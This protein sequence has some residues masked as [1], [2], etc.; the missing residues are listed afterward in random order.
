MYIHTC[1]E[2]VDAIKKK[3]NFPAKPLDT[4]SIVS[5]GAN[6]DDK[7]RHLA[8]NIVSG[9][10]RNGN[11]YGFGNYFPWVHNTSMIKDRGNLGSEVYYTVL[12]D[13]PE[14]FSRAFNKLIKLANSIKKDIKIEIE[15]AYKSRG[16]MNPRVI[17][18]KRSIVVPAE[19]SSLKDIKVIDHIIENKADV[20][21]I[22]SN[23]NTMVSMLE[24][25][26]NTRENRFDFHVQ[27]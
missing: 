17:G 27:Y 25:K 18:Y 23:N 20:M 14:D 24:N 22:I 9:W 11:R 7:S 3:C 10:D 1:D 5:I 2:I 8:I 21:K 26:M 4:Y 19:A 16:R 6:I 15:T 13:N 12:G